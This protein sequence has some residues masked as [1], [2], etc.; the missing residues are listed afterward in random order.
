MSVLIV[1]LTRTGVNAIIFI[2]LRGNKGGEEII[3]K[4]TEYSLSCYEITVSFPP[5]V[6]DPLNTNAHTYTSRSS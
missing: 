4:V 2:F 6:T 5:L 1:V 3:S